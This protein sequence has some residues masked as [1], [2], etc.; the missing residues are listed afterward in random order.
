MYVSSHMK[1]FIERSDTKWTFVK[2]SNIV[3]K[4]VLD[5]QP[6]LGTGSLPDWLHNLAPQTQN[7][8]EGFEDKFCLWRCNTFYQGAH[9]NRSTQAA[10]EFAKSYFN[11]TV[12]A[13]LKVLDEL[14]R[15][16][17]WAQ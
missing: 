13:P 7:G 3:V 2:F 12:T 4:V 9:P 6:M 8:F 15:W 5:N 17:I 11:L 1:N 10:S 14:A 16:N